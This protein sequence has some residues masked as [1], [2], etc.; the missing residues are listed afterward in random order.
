[1]VSTIFGWFPSWSIF[2]IIGIGILIVVI[3]YFMGQ[4]QSGG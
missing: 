4:R 1:M 2:F 3:L